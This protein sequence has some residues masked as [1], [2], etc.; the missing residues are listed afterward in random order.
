MTDA[1]KAPESELT[2]GVNTS[3]K[4]PKKKKIWYQLFGLLALVTLSGVLIPAVNGEPVRPESLIATPF[5][6]GIFFAAIWRYREKSRFLGFGL[7]A[8]SGVLAIFLVLFFAG[9]LRR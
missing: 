8:I 4:E 3:K 1:Y 2:D 7:G 6:F 9:F 5:W